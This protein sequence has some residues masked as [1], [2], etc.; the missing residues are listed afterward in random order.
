MGDELKNK[1]LEHNGIIDID[2][3]N[4]NMPILNCPRC[5]ITNVFENKYCSK[6][7]YPL[8]PETFDEIKLSEEDKIRKLEEKH[9]HDMNILREEMEDR[10]QQLFL[11]IDIQKLGR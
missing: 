11:R 6:C 8:K 2:P 1:I 10:F 9:N 4:K 7:S 5:E 3:T